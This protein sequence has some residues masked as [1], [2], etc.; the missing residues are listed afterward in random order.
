MSVNFI[1][2]KINHKKFLGIIGVLT[3]LLGAFSLARS[4]FEYSGEIIG[5]ETRQY[6]PLFLDN[7]AFKISL[8]LIFA[9][10]VIQL[11]EKIWDDIPNKY[12]NIVYLIINISVFLLVLCSIFYVFFG[13][14]LI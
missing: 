9:G 5:N 11:F 10:F 7:V 14:K 8:Y 2:K 3:S 6:H 12:Y 13:I 4:S 1:S